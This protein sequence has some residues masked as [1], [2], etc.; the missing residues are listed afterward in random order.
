MTV[1]EMISGWSPETMGVD[2]EVLEV[3]RAPHPV[4][5]TEGA[6]VDPLDPT[7]TQLA[8][9]LVATID[10][11]SDLNNSSPEQ[12]TMVVSAPPVIVARAVSSPGKLTAAAL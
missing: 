5:A 10:L 6:T 11:P 9:D 8:A 3:V 1:T 7:I 2:G 12:P 4:L